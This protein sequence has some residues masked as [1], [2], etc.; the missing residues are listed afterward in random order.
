M[1]YVLWGL[2]AAVTIVFSFQ[3]CKKLASESDVEFLSVTR[4]DLAQ[5]TLLSAKFFVDDPVTYARVH[6]KIDLQTG[7]ITDSLLFNYCLSENLRSELNIFLNSSQ[8][9]QIRR[10]FP[11]DTYCTMA[12]SE[13]Y[14]E[15]KTVRGE[16]ALG[17][18]SD[19]CATYTVD[20][21]EDQPTALKAWLENLKNTY[22]QMTCSF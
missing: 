21:C 3:N 17:Y 10:P 15:L 4:I 16:F 8:V 13:P 1:K 19:G 9:C 5:E 14:L 20:L 18:A 6:F 11:K 2:F 12:I 22:Q 7:V